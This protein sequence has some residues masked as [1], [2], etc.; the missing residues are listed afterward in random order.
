MNK[1]DKRASLGLES[2]NEF[3]AHG[4]LA[5]VSSQNVTDNLYR[6]QLNG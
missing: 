6:A 2:G 3:G 5:Q 4:A 1:G